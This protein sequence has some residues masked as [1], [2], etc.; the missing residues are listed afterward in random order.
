MVQ[1]RH[2]YKNKV[3]VLA[4]ARVHS[5]TQL[6]EADFSTFQHYKS[7][8]IATYSSTVYSLLTRIRQQKKTNLDIK[9][10]VPILDTKTMLKFLNY[11]Q[12]TS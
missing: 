5:P 1:P 7:Q 3:R 2:N 10:P 4:I 11:T 8:K 6:T 12:I 9:L